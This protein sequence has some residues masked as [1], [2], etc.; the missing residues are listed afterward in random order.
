MPQDD[1]LPLDPD[2]LDFIERNLIL[3]PVVEPGRL[4]ACMVGHLLCQFKLS[5]VAQVLGDAGGT[6]VVAAD[7]CV[8]RGV[9]GSAADHPVDVCL[10]IGSG[11]LPEVLD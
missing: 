4:C 2:A 1:T 11:D 3:S 6:E 9:T 7:L 8:D 10:A 5:S